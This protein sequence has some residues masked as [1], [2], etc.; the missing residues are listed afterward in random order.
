MDTIELTEDIFGKTTENLFERTTF[1]PW[2]KPRKHWIRIHQWCSC[3]QELLARK[4]FS[5]ISVLNY[6][7][8][9]GEDCLD[10]QTIGQNLP[11]GKKIKYLG[12]EKEDNTQYQSIVESKLHDT[13]YISNESKICNKTHLEELESDYSQITNDIFYGEPFHII[14]LDLTT[15]LLPPNKGALMWKS[16][17]RLLKCQ[18]GKQ[19][20]PW[21]LFLTTRCDKEAID[22]IFFNEK[23]S[24]FLDN[25]RNND[26]RH[27]VNTEIKNLKDDKIL[28]REALLDSTCYE[29]IVLLTII[30][31]IL[32]N[33]VA[34]HVHMCTES[35]ISYRIEETS[36]N[37]EMHSIVLRF[38]KEKNISDAT[39]TPDE[40]TKK[41]MDAE[42]LDIASRSGHKVASCKNVDDIL[43]EHPEIKSD[44]VNKT[45]EMLKNIG[46]DITQYIYD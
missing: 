6:F 31:M 2:H 26:F 16:I 27:I 34:K 3:V 22:E 23:F 38:T 45:K 41:R 17:L 43:T 32:K 19:T 7:G 4:E 36:C 40:E 1:Q 37:P 25:Y 20:Y 21:L 33:A 44:M 5:E 30:K 15:S 46:Y 11:K 8:M 12:I 18:F 39:V 14:N 24:I 13:P 10:I 42:E 9:P 28:N 29:K 35:V